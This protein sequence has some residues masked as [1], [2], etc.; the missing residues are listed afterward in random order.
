MTTPARPLLLLL[1][2]TFTSALAGGCEP[3]RYGSSE[4]VTLTPTVDELQRL[5]FSN[6][7]RATVVAGSPSRVEITV[8]QNLQ[9]QLV[10]R[11]SHG[12]LE[13]GMQDGYDYQRLILN[14]RVTMPAVESI[15][16]G[17]ASSADLLGFEQTSV[18]ALNVE[19]SGASRL[20]GQVAA[21][22]LKLDLSGASRAQLGG[23]TREL[24]LV[25]SGASEAG[26]DQLQTADASVELS[27]ASRAVVLVEREIRGEAS[28]ASILVVRGS[29][30]M[31]VSTSGASSV[32]RR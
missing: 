3:M 14:V 4:T 29:G 8:N 1:L 26:L 32:S 5:A 11:T 2:L 18:A 28:G 9:D 20:S 21:D 6:E 22:R 13:V 30:A 23:T 31:N 16:L 27:G 25:A 15:V 24:S 19:V 7:V 17:G 10:V 12:Q